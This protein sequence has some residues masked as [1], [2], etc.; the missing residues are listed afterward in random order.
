MLLHVVPI[1]DASIF[2]FYENGRTLL[3]LIIY[4]LRL[5]GCWCSFVKYSIFYKFYGTYVMNTSD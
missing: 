2:S 4:K 1:S 3:P 5:F